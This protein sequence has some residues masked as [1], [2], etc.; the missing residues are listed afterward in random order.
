VIEADGRL[1]FHANPQ[2]AYSI[3]NR[4][5]QTRKGSDGRTS[6]LIGPSAPQDPATSWL[7][8][9]QGRLALVFR[10]YLPQP[11]L[12]RGEWLLP[13]VPPV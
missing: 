11:A 13:G 2:Q 7:P 1:F 3:S 9:A 6:I 8:S 10:A 5:P 4:M 12:R